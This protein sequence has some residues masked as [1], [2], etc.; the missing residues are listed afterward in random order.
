M[1]NFRSF[2]IILRNHSHCIEFLK[3]PVSTKFLTLLEY[4][5][6]ELYS[7]KTQFATHFL[8]VAARSINYRGGRQT[9]TDRRKG[10]SSFIHLST[11]MHLILVFA[12][13]FIDVSSFKEKFHCTTTP[14]NVLKNGLPLLLSKWPD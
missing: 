3:N 8:H 5:E 7:E 10:F 14:R 4:D 2:E 11:N 13:M 12:W 1:M 6:H 9:L